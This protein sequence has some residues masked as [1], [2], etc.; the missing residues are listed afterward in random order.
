MKLNFKN[1]LKVLATGSIQEYISAFLR[2]DD[3]PNIDQPVDTD[4]AL[5][6]SAVFGCCRVL[7]E[8]FPSAPLILYKK[9]GKDRIPVTEVGNADERAMV[10]HD[11]MHNV[12]NEEMSAF[13]SNEAQMYSLNLGGNAV[14]EKLV[15]KN[16]DIIGLYPYPHHMA[17][18][19]RNKD[20][21]RLEYKI[22]IG[23]DIK[24][25]NRSQV[26]HVPGPSLDGVIGMSPISYAAAAIS[27]GLSY[28]K[29]GIKFYKNSAN[30]SGVFQTDNSLSDQA[31]IRLKKDLKENYTGLKNTG[32]PMI[33]E[34]GMKWAQMTINPVDAQ[35]LESKY[36]QIEDIC[37]IYRVPQHLVNKLDRS[38]NNNI[39]YQSLEFVM[40]TMLPIYKRFEGCQNAQLVSQDLRKKGYFF[41]YKMDGLLRGDSAARAALYANGRMWGWLSANDIRKLENL[42]SLGPEGAIYLQPANYIKAGTNT[43]KAYAKLVDEIFKMIEERRGAA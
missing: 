40:Y 35:L 24:T 4:I 14:C 22:G 21:K 9:E 6:Y 25:L 32:T 38:T 10:L 27:L 1:R 30:P 13:N 39:E 3:V 36:F 15:N 7:G 33:L 8:T 19:E 2:G 23:S 16:G 12:P 41:E 5:K 31:F 17:K 43:Q 29:F 37:R 34:E 20:T 28:E 11:V 18:V 42:P 26:L